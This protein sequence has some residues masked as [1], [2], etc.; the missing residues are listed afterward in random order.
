MIDLQT[1]RITYMGIKKVLSRF[2]Y[3]EAP[4]PVRGYSSLKTQFPGV[5]PPSVY[6]QTDPTRL[7]ATTAK[8]RWEKLGSPDFFAIRNTD[9][10]WSKELQHGSAF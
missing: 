1:G 9:G 10:G 2:N 7:V 3:S 6:H 4:V 5:Y 8:E